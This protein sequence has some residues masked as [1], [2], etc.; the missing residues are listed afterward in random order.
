MHEYALIANIYDLQFRK[1][2]EEAEM[3]K[4]LIELEKQTEI[5]TKVDKQL[6]HVREQVQQI[7]ESKA[8]FIRDYGKDT[9]MKLLL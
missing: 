7:C 1:E 3:S 6:V 9:Y 4:V 8:Q 5:L 2:A